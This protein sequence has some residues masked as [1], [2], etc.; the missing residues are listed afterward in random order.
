MITAL[1]VVVPEKGRG[2]KKIINKI[3]QDSVIVELRRA[4]GV[5]LKYITYKSYSGKIKLDKLDCVVENQR[6]RLLCSRDYAFPPKSGYMRFSSSAFTARLCTNMAYEVVKG[7][8]HPE[9]LK[10]GIYDPDAAAPDI[11]F[12]ILKYCS[13]VTVVTNENATYRT[14]LDK[15]LDELGAT[16]IITDREE[17]LSEC[18]LV[19]APSNITKP[20]PVKS[21]TVLLTNG[22]P[23]VQQSGMIYYKYY[24][25]MPNGFANIKPQELDEEYFCSALYTLENQYELGS[26]VPTMCSNSSTSQ[27]VSSLV[28]YLNRTVT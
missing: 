2:L 28:A 13:D 6:S 3:R 27:T 17:E 23:K 15:A 5:C 10:V 4:R 16:A 19:I 21:N 14:Q 25:R 11:L 9:K 7:C 1:N 26:I 18:N 8:E 24:L 12:Y 20:I 22:Q